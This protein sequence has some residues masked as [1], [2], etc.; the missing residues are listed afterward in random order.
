MKNRWDV[1]F[2]PEYFVP[3]TAQAVYRRKLSHQCGSSPDSVV[4]FRGPFSA[5]TFQKSFIEGWRDLAG[6]WNGAS[7][8]G[9][10]RGRETGERPDDARQLGQSKSET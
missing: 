9:S 3:L 2:R 10:K 6:V 7:G 5:A 1:W 4:P 8:E